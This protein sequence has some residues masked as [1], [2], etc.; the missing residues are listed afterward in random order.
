MNVKALAGV[1]SF[2]S[3]LTLIFVNL[4]HATNF[5]SRFSAIKQPSLFA[6]S[7]WQAVLIGL[8]SIAFLVLLYMLIFE[9]R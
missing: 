4:W 1:A 7:H 6:A 2:I 5:A 8:L 3:A 9:E